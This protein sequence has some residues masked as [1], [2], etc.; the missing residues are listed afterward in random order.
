MYKQIGVIAVLLL[1][2]SG[3]GKSTPESA[4]A[5]SQPVIAG[6]VTQASYDNAVKETLAHAMVVM[7]SAKPTEPELDADIGKIEALLALSE[8]NDVDKERAHEAPLMSTLGTL[9]AR[10]AANN[11]TNPRTAGALIAK[12]YRYLDKAITLHPQDLMAKID[13]GLISAHVPDFLGKAELAHDDL[14]S[15]EEHAEFDK[16]T[17]ELQ[18]TIKQALAEVDSRLAKAGNGQ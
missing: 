6:E 18:N 7:N 11:S 4:G 3:C 5:S 8:K 2:L 17:P 10:K 15:V 1:A 14:K 13:R 12:S 16:L 9:Y